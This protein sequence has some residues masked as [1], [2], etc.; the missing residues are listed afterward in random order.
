MFQGGVKF[1]TGGKVHAPYGMIRCNSETDGIVR[2]KETWR[3]CVYALTVF[4][5][6]VF[7]CKAV[8]RPA[9]RSQSWQAKKSAF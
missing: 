8:P 7:L 9:E 2:M 6:G 5:V 1:S 4:T 3:F